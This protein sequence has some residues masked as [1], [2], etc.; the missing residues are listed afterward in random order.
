MFL[1]V[2]ISPDRVGFFQ[3]RA[4]LAGSGEV[5]SVGQSL[6]AFMSCRLMIIDRQHR[7]PVT[8]AVVMGQGFEN[9]C[10]QT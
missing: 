10:F 9:Y 8:A 3:F 1:M 4:P 7:L 6:Y 2:R 5:A